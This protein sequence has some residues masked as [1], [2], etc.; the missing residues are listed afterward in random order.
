MSNLSDDEVDE[1]LLAASTPR[2]QK[3]SMVIAKAMSAYDTWD[4][5]KVGRRVVAL[6]RAGALESLGDV[7][8]WRFSEVRVPPPKN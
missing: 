1:L 6:V 5:V 8:D 7:R 3:V 4:E 2:W